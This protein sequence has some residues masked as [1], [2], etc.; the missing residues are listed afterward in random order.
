MTCVDVY[1]HTCVLVL[2]A[3][4]LF[5]IILHYFPDK[6]SLT[7]SGAHSSGKTS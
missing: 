6:R 3:V 2:M 4:R 7:E 1:R 5:Y